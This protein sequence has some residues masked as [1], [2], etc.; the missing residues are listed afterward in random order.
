MITVANRFTVKKGFATRMAPAFVSD[1]SLLNWDGFHKIE[2]N[3]CSKAEEHDELNVMMFW[4]TYEH[5]EAWRNS[6]DFKNS[7]KRDVA[8][9]S[10]GQDQSPILSNQIVVADLVATLVK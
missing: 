1:Q 8:K 6:D 5:F 7:H 2:V 3:V 9:T 4:D 10:D